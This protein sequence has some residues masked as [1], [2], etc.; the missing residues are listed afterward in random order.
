MSEATELASILNAQLDRIFLER[1]DRT[2]LRGAEVGLWPAALWDE[3]EALGLPL[4]LVPEDAGGVGL[5]WAGAYEAFKTLGRYCVPLPIGE[6]ALAA[7]LLADAGLDIP[8]GVLTLA[9]ENGDNVPWARNA[10]HLVLATTE[11][12]G[13]RIDC[14][15]LVPA[16]ITPGMN[17]GRDPRDTV[18]LDGLTIVQTGHIAAT[19]LN[20]VLEW[21]ALL[22]SG[23]IAGALAAVRGLSID[24]ANVRVQF[25][26]PIRTFQAVQQSLATLA[27]EA[28]AAAVAGA[29][30]AAARD[31]GVARFETAVAKIRA[32]E[33]AGKGAAL[34]HQAHGAIGF[35]DDYSLHDLTRR[36]WSWRAEYGTERYWAEMIGRE[37]MKSGR[38]LWSLITEPA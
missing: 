30:A 10:G 29:T 34:G 9:A 14:I 33:S 21:G 12:G 35:T 38:S 16:A 25:G 4:L 5:S 23:Q 26:K 20:P 2:A 18:A 8:S 19:G 27:S 31:R 17:M 28:A 1:L 36:L 15:K 24:Y 6:T 11:A 22:R 13:F 37:A 32:G 3:C 7:R